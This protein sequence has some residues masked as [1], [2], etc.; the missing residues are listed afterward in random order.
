MQLRQS[1]YWVIL[2]FFLVLTIEIVGLAIL[3]RILTPAQM[4]AYALAFATIR[5]LQ[6]LAGFGL[7]NVVVQSPAMDRADR[8]RIL[9]I[10]LVTAAVASAAA[11]VVAVFMPVSLLG[12]EVQ[13]LVR[14]MAPTILP[15]CLGMIS[16]AL[17]SR[18]LRFGPL[19]A[20][21]V[22]ASLAFPAIAIPLALAGHGPA[23]LALGYAASILCQFI[24]G[25]VLTKGAFVLRPRLTGAG[26]SFR[27]GSSLFT[28]QSLNEMAE[29]AL[30]NL[31][32]QMLGMASVALLARSRDLVTRANR[33]I[34]E[35]IMPALNPHLAQARRE[36]REI[37]SSFLQ[38]LTNLTAISIPTAIML[39]AC[40]ANVVLVLLGEQWLAAIPIMRVLAMGLA[41][42]PLAGFASTFLLSLHMQRIL[43]ARGAVFLAGIVVIGLLSGRIGLQLAVMGLVGLQFL[44][45][46]SLLAVAGLRLRVAMRTSLAAMI[47]SIPAIVG[48]AL[49][50]FAVSALLADTGWHPALA[51]LVQLAAGGIG[52]LLG[53]IAARHPLCDEVGHALALLGRGPRSS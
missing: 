36:G 39:S 34:V 20:L 13:P 47:P 49:A 40:A 1:L 31:I 51:L 33:A 29:V 9:G 46:L 11:V 32:G 4:G 10:V 41:V 53:M 30:P 7:F 17:I 8:A 45:A 22:V 23:S 27:L 28:S 12:G 42:T 50:V 38:G 44:L 25:V 37:A 35:T 5:F 52:W 16:S 2:Q 19:L 6:F 18:Q 24:L 21:R 43:V 14:M 26:P 3:A 48:T 15:A